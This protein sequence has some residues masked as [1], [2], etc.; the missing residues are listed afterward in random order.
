M[1]KIKKRIIKEALFIINNNATIRQTATEFKVGKSTI[2]KDMTERLKP[3]NLSL[4]KRVQ[5]V[6]N[7]HLQ[8]RH[9]RGGE[10][11]KRKYKLL[12]T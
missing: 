12:R 8:T 10:V 5:Q 2:H 9:I 6:M 1:F 11:T 7:E 4:F 3:I